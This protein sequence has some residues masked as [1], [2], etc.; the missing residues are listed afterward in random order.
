MDHESAIKYHY[1]YY[2]TGSTPFQLQFCFNFI[3]NLASNEKVELEK[4]GVRVA[5][6]SNC[7]FWQ[8]F[9]LIGNTF[10]GLTVRRF[11]PFF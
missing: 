5:T 7:V 6:I 9:E 4:V 8:N 11:W 1:Y 2:L 3:T 10:F